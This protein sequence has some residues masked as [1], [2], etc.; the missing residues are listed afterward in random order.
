MRLARLLLLAAAVIAFASPATAGDDK[1]HPTMI[2]CKLTY[3]LKGWSLVYA[4]SKG[5]GRITCSNGASANVALKSYGGGFTVGKSE[6]IGGK[7]K[8]SEVREIDALFGAYA[9]A[10]A[11]AG[12]GEAVLA[13]VVTKGEISLTLT[14][15]GKGVNLGVSVGNFVITKKE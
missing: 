6:V 4:Q 8:F 3:N 10:E 7:G 9:K 13:T 2:K 5:E 11:H 14:G 15:T 1:F 12:A